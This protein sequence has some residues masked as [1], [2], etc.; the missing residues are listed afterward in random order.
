MEA[1]KYFTRMGD[2][3]IVY[4]TEEEIRAD[5]EKGVQDAADRGKIPPLTQAEMEHIYDIVTMPGGVVG[6]EPSL[7][8]VTSNDSG[9][10][11]FSTKCGIPV[12]R[13]VNAMFHERVLG[14]DSVDIG[15]E[16]Y[17]YKTVKGVAKREAAV[18]KNALNKTTIPLFYGAMPNLGFYTKPDGPVDNWAVLLP[19]GKIK[20]ALEAQEEAVE[21]AVRDIVYVAEQMY[22]VGADGI[23]LDTSGAAGDADF[24]V[25]LK[26]TEIIREKFPDMGV[27]IGMAGEFVLG[28]H[29]RLK[30]NGVKLAGLYPH[31][32]VKL[33][34]EAGASIFGAVV[35]TNCNMSFPWNIAR[36]CTFIKACSE[37]ASIPV[38][39][40]AGMGVCAIPM[41]ETLPADIVS[42]ADKCLIEICKIDGL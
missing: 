11:K 35:N 4:M 40:N 5:I 28:M 37:A 2:G 39:A 25:S 36:V 26:A 23:Q 10:D 27:E 24:L 15:L 20:E 32:Q 17:N 7:A 19:E 42:R 3:S 34:E 9:S 29:G 8:V 22:D 6:V 30:Y 31:Q 14:A 12:E 21:H 38:H 16:D 1:K 41:C 33:V 13:S 18:L